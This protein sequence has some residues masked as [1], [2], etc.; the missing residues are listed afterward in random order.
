MKHLLLIVCIA[1]LAVSL[2]AQERQSP[3]RG[4]RGVGI[5]L[6][7][8]TRGAGFNI[9]HFRGPDPN[10]PF[11]IGLALNA[12]RDSREVLI[13]SAYGEQGKRYV[14][15]KVNHLYVLTPSVGIQRNLFPLHDNNQVNVRLGVQA[16]P[17]I[18]LLSPYMVEIFESLPGN[19]FYG[20]RSVQQFNPENHS[21]N[22]I[23][24]K[25]NF[26]SEPLNLDFILGFSI[27][28]SVWIDFSRSKHYISAVQLGMQADIFPKE[29]PIMVIGPNRQ[30]FVAGS[31]GLVFGNRW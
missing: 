20:R 7:L 19:S 15:G 29:A 4:F 9:D 27:K 6:H 3:E 1:A 30:L 22:D 13:E 18:G 25:A 8:T 14:Y 23:I 17:A 12:V 2:H 28:G 16:G 26:L 5:G 24:G 10:R 21:Y 11:I 31:I